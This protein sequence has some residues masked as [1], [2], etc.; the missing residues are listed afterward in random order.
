MQLFEK[1]DLLLGKGKWNRFRMRQTI[2]ELGT[3]ALRPVAAP[4]LDEREK[5]FNR[6]MV[7]N[8]RETNVNV[9]FLFDQPS[10]GRR[11]ERIKPNFE[12][13]LVE[14]HRIC[15]EHLSA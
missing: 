10:Q 1:P 14:P 6:G 13:G 8:L 2:D 4:V 11:G 5:P 7:E 3:H 15:S 9:K 12:K